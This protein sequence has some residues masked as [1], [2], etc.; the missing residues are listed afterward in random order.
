MATS[1]GQ[2]DAYGA[3][4]SGAL[5]PMALTKPVVGTAATTDGEG[6]YLV[7]SDGGVFTFGDARYHGSTG[8]DHLNRPIVGMAVDPATGGYW[9]VASDGG[10]FSFDAPFFGS[11][12]S[13]HLNQPVVGMAPTPDGRGYYLVASDGGIFTF[14]DARF[15]GSTGAE[16]LN[17]PIVGMAVDTATGG[18]WLVASDGGIFSFDTPFLGSTGGTRLNAPI[19]SMTPTPGGAGYYLVAADG[20]VFTFGNAPFEGSPAGPDPYGPWVGLIVGP[21][22]GFT[23]T[24][25][26]TPS[27]GHPYSVTLRPFGGSG[28]YGQWEVTSGSLPPGLTLAPFLGTSNGDT[29]SYGPMTTITGVPTSYGTFGFT[30]TLQDLG[31]H[32][33]SKALELTIAPP[34]ES[35]GNAIDVVTGGNAGVGGAWCALLSNGRVDCWGYNI[36]GDLGAGLSW[37]AAVDV[38]AP[39]AVS[40]IT[41]ARGIAANDSDVSNESF[42]AWLASGGARC[43]GSDE[44]GQLGGGVD[45]SGIDPVTFGDVP[46]PVVGLDAPVSDIVGGPGGAYCALLTSGS[47]S[48]WGSDAYGELGAGID[49]TGTNAA[50]SDVAVPVTGI[51][52][53]SLVAG[54]GSTFC[55]VLVSGG[56][57]CWGGNPD[58]EL[59]AGQTPIAEPYSDRPVTTGI[60]GAVRVSSMG[61]FPGFCAQLTGGSVDCWGANNLGQVGADISSPFVDTPTPAVGVTDVDAIL[62]NPTGT[63][64]AVETTGAVT[65]WGNNSVGQLGR[66]ADPVTEPSSGLPQA[67]GGVDAQSISTTEGDY[68]AV[69]AGGGVDCWGQNGLGQLGTGSTSGYSD[70][71]VPVSGITGARSVFSLGTGDVDGF[72]SELTSGQVECWGYD[73]LGVQPL[74]GVLNGLAGAVSI[75]AGP[76]RSACALVPNGQV[77]CWGS[78]ASGEL[79]DGGN[80]DQFASQPVTV[81]GIGP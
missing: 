54:A 28:Q 24:A 40:G 78:N 59:G 51:D 14:G 25:L 7:A 4:Q 68:C 38:N 30:I 72:C 32:S 26:P 60:S 79:G 16:H 15:D 39:V 36:N 47:V 74:P 31:G 48:C 66:G 73:D 55:A 50:Y 57:D 63:T 11:T 41:T 43:W 44:N 64:C 34:P 75:V 1:E 3:P 33:Y 58:G 67:V 19:V 81:R 80:P 46:V 35:P 37:P 27:I 12:G 17:R 61:G 5:Y 53:T 8:A 21:S 49:P 70:V 18:Y 29:G 10:I 62:S 13:V 65:C 23:P 52:A 6:Y 22:L 20:G 71:P 9:L 77:K 69:L 2:V 42:C 56:V 45:P 76:Y